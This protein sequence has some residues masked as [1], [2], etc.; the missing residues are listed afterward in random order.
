MNLQKIIE[1]CQ[2]SKKWTE[3]EEYCLTPEFQNLG[4]VE[5]NKHF[6]TSS[7]LK[8]FEKCQ[9]TYKLKHVDLIPDPT[10]KEAD[11]FIVGR[12]LDDL[13][14]YGQDY[15]Q[16]TYETVARRN[17]KAQK[18]Q[19]T[20]TMS[21]LIDQMHHEFKNQ[22]VF[23]PNPKKKVFF[24]EVA[25]FILK[26]E[27][28]DY[29]NGII[30]DIKTTAN[31]L[32]FDPKDYELQMSF[33]HWLVEENTGMRPRVFL[34]VVDKYTH[35]SRSKM[36]EYSENCLLGKRAELL[37]LLEKL[38]EAHDLNI[39]IRSNIEQIVF[40]SPYYGHPQYG[41]WTETQIY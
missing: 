34:E 8:D 12:A 29:E 28:D 1:K 9:L 24:H 27:M 31:I 21:K 40:N 35:F 11:Y 20:N 37:S 30:R 5:K 22:T 38:R 39:F 6:I 36:I 16:S 14:T 26:A 10:E 23:A 7:K 4:Y 25:G 41:R 2:K 15:Y 13:L 32:T 17:E 33:Y 19:L 3:L 18:V